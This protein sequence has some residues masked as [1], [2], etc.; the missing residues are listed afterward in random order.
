MIYTLTGLMMGRMKGP[1]TRRQRTVLEFIQRCIDLEGLAPTLR[2]I[3]EH[4]GFSSTAS[5][6]KHIRALVE[7]GYLHKEK[8]RSR[9]LKAPDEKGALLLGAVAAGSPIEN[10]GEEE[11]IAIPPQMLGAG[12]HFVLKVRGLSMIE[13]GIHDGDLIVVRRSSKAADGDLVVALIE[14]EAT[15]KRFYRKPGNMI[16]LQPANARMTAQLLPAA[17]VEIQ[18]IVSGLMRRY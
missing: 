2:E 4:F 8:H 11:R 17:R 1:L 12:E 3:S 9:G 13:E 18:G 10:F 14:G 7:K 5:A 15:L 16:L 6:Q